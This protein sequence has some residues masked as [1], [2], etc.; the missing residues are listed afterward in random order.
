MPG[1]GKHGPS[2]VFV[3]LD[4]YDLTAEKIN[5]ASFEEEAETAEITG[6]GDS[7]REFTPTGMARVAIE[8]GGAVFDTCASRSHDMLSGGLPASPQT[9][10]RLAVIGMTGSTVGSP[11]E[12][13]EGAHQV[14]YNVLATHDDLQRANAAYQITGARDAG[15]IVHPLGAETTEGNTRSTSVDNGAGPTTFGGVA[16]LH[17]SV[18]IGGFDGLQSEIQDSSD[19]ITFGTL[20]AFASASSTVDG[21]ARAQRVTVAG[22]VQRYTAMLWSYEGAGPG[23]MTFFSMFSRG[24]TF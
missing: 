11:C 21:T 7:F 4:G 2:E 16:H 18:N 22:E 23:T 3:F 12:A 1:P 24:S 10:A 9:A 8:L 17:I 13:F 6:L 15:R 20:V 19:D 14:S 5:T